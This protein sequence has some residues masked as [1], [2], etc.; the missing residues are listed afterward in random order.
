[1]KSKIHTQSRLDKIN[2]LLRPKKINPFST[3][4]IQQSLDITHT[5]QDKKYHSTKHKPNTFKGSP[6][7]TATRYY[8]PF[9][10]F[11]ENLVRQDNVLN[12][13]KM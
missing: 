1:M 6:K 2:F 11:T 3:E 4:A 8:N 7:Y 12:L 10:R 9:R 13:H 5:A